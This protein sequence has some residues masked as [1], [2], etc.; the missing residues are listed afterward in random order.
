MP[1]P[2]PP[3]LDAAQLEQPGL[4]GALIAHRCAFAPSFNVENAL[5]AMRRQQVNFAAVLDGGSVI[6]Q[7][8]RHE[9][10][11]MIGSRF[12]FAL[13]GRATLREFA[14][15]PSLIVTLGDPIADVLSALNQRSGAAFDDDV[16]LLD[17]NGSFL[18]LSTRERS[19]TCSI[20]FF[21]RRSATS[22]R[23]R[24]RSIA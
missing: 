5:S 2:E 17:S 19:F 21:C 9:I 11:E 16:M 15:T 3:P 20:S 14:T 13:Y 12:G 18:G 7:I 6:G 4:L 10:D 24:N 1:A 23:R 22:P 8:S